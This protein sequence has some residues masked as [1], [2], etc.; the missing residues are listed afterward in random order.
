MIRLYLAT[1]FG[2]SSV[3][4]HPINRETVQGVK[5][6]YMSSASSGMSDVVAR[7][8]LNGAMAMATYD[9]E[10]RLQTRRQI[11]N[12]QA[13]A[14]YPSL[15]RSFASGFIHSTGVRTR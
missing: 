12:W 10:I 4:K 7:D 15:C 1:N 14:R 13:K 11:R 6:L 5:Q 3:E 9:V 2:R 8:S